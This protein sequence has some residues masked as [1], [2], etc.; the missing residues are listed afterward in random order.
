MQFVKADPH[1]ASMLMGGSVSQ[2]VQTYLQGHMSN[3]KNTLGTIGSSLMNEVENITERFNSS[4]ALRRLKALQN[5]T[6]SVFTEDSVRYL[7]S[8]GEIQTAKSVMQQY[9]VA[10]QNT[11]ELIQNDSIGSYGI[12]DDMTDNE[13]MIHA[14]HMRNR[15]MSGIGVIEDGVMVHR[16]YT[17]YEPDDNFVGLTHR[18]KVNIMDTWAALAAHYESESDVKASPTSIL[19]DLIE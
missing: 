16:T 13:M 1:S 6:E 11:F 4:T 10:E 18:D 2:G 19:N 9:I 3:L 12:Y 17:Q 7:G 14:N 15:V 5:V 8:I